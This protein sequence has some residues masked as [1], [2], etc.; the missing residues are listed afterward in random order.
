MSERYFVDTPLMPSAVEAGVEECCYDLKGCFRLDETGGE[1][2]DV[3]IVMLTGESGEFGVPTNCGAHFGVFVEGHCYSVAGSAESDSG[4]EV[5][6]FHRFG[7]WV[8]EVG[9]VAT[10]L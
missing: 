2:E 3:G 9:I 8:C 10:F 1:D 7:A 6:P 4:G 5:A